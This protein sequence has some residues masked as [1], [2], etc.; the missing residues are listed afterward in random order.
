MTQPTADNP[1]PRPGWGC[2]FFSAPLA[3]ALLIAAAYGVL[4]GAGMLGASADGERVTITF[5]TCPEAQ[6]LLSARVDHMG[7]GDPEWTERS[8][9]LSLTATLPGT[10]IAEHI[11]PTLARP[12]G[13]TLRTGPAREDPILLDHRALQSAEFSLKELGNPL[14]LLR[15]TASARTELIAHMESAPDGHISIWVDDELVLSRP[16]DPP[17][18]RDEI[19]VRAEG[20]DGRDNIR[21]AVD[22]AMLMTF[23]PLPC[24]TRL[25]QT[26][27]AEP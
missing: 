9:R 15:L 21:R 18:R 17:F 14:V 13:F 20:A 23:G 25:V 1:I 19:D 8:S 10:E 22:W 11:P 24:P 3:F 6:P 26:R 4:F 16:N 5:E 7:L 12:G 27:R 2:F